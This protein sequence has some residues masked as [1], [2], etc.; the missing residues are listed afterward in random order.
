MSISRRQFFRGLTGPTQEQIRDRRTR[1]V[2]M[3]VRTNHFPYDFA[4]T[5]EQVSEALTAAVAGIDLD[6]V[7]QDILPYM[8]R[9]QVRDIVDEKIQRWRDESFRAEDVRRDALKV[10]EEFLSSEATP[11][12]REKLRQRFHIPYPAVLEEEVERQARAWL[13]G[14][15][16]A[17]LAGSDASSIREL[18]FS[19]LRSWC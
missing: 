14:L 15:S 5:S 13:S 1:I 6:K 2:E 3:Y 4:L 18:V 12:D 17:F 7:T 10:V 19:E 9:R 16:N 11:E 8:Q